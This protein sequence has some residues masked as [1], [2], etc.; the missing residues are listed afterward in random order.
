[1]I[2]P[3]CLT[4][5]E[6]TSFP[7][8][9]NQEVLNANVQFLKIASSSAK[10]KAQAAFTV[11]SLR[12][13]YCSFVIMIKCTPSIV[14]GHLCRGDSLSCYIKH[15]SCSRWKEKAMKNEQKSKMPQCLGPYDL[16]KG[17][18]PSNAEEVSFSW[19]IN[20]SKYT[21]ILCFLQSI[22]GK[23]SVLLCFF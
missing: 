19:A 2:A 17:I 15:L 23:D 1:M 3:D 18:P 13:R 20:F 8:P 22:Y 9:Q 16:I 5:Q 10:A 6:T 12:P 14:E 21:I 4:V 7:D 11:F